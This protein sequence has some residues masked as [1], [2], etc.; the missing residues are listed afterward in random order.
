LVPS[1]IRRREKKKKRA[2]GGLKEKG[3]LG[4]SEN[5]ENK[6]F[7]LGGTK[8]PGAGEPKKRKKETRKKKR[9]GVVVF[10]GSGKHGEGSKKAPTV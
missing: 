9:V 6:G 3:E 1:D 10:E 8:G 4:G 5:L 2:E 7:K